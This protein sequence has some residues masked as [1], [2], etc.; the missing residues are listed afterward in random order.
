LRRSTWRCRLPAVIRQRC[1]TSRACSRTTDR[2]TSLGTSPIGWKIRRW[3][4]FEVRHIT[5]RPRVRSSPSRQIAKQS[6][7]GQWM[8]PDTEEPRFAGKLLPAGRVGTGDWDV[9]QSLQSPPLPQ[10]HWQ[11]HTGGCL[12]RARATNPGRKEKDQRG[13]LQTA[14]LAQSSAGRIIRNEMVGA[15]H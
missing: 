7:A 12:L 14:L 4:M 8:A 2:V 6:P 9:H 13:N 11:R 15:L 1:C 10:K 5:R 3:N